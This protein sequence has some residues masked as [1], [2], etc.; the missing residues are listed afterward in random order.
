MPTLN[1][2]RAGASRASAGAAEDGVRVE[3][4]LALCGESAEV[5]A[6]GPLEVELSVWPAGTDSLYLAV[7][8]DRARQRPADVEFSAALEESDAELT[9]PAAL[10]SVLGGPV[11]V[12]ELSRDR[13]FRQVL[14]VNQFLTLERLR[15]ALTPGASGTLRIR[16]RRRLRLGLDRRRPLEAPLVVSADLEIRIPIVRNDSALEEEILK[17]VA[18]VRGGDLSVRERAL[19]ILVSLRNPTADRQFQSLAG[20]DDAS[21]R[22]LGERGLRSAQP[23]SSP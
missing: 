16:C 12:T 17:L 20:D 22:A 5:L 14:L 2:P 1:G 11:T 3:L 9:D 15:P 4:S 6:G 23:G 21:V 18:N 10:V 19:A 8:A 13:P 7:A